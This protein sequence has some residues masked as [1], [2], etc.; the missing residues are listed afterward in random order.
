[1]VIILP[2][3]EILKRE[4]NDIPSRPS[5]PFCMLF[6]ITSPGTFRAL[7]LEPRAVSCQRQ[8]LAGEGRPREVWLSAQI[9]RGQIV[10][11]ADD[12]MICAP[13]LTVGFGLFVIVV[14]SEP[15]PPVFVSQTGAHHAA[16]GEEF[17]EVKH[18]V[19]ALKAFLLCPIGQD[20]DDQIGE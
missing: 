2:S 17:E 14:V 7:R 13:V 3:V 16:A 5:I 1:M 4:R 15:A 10:H 11:I 9:V 18:R 12:Q 19:S 8:I 6:S 20:F